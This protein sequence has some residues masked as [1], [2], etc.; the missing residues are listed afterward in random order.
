MYIINKNLN[1][2]FLLKR[3]FTMFFALLIVALGFLL[4]EHDMNAQDST[5]LSSALTITVIP[6]P[7]VELVKTKCDGNPDGDA[8][9][10]ND[11]DV[12][13]YEVIVTFDSD[14]GAGNTLGVNIAAGTTTD[15]FTT[16]A[17]Q[18]VY[19]FSSDPANPFA[20]VTT[21]APIPVTTAGIV[22]ATFTSGGIVYTSDFVLAAEANCSCFR[23]YCTDVTNTADAGIT[24]PDGPLTPPTGTNPLLETIYVLTDPSGAI[25]QTDDVDPTMVEF[26]MSALAPTSAGGALCQVWA[27]NFD[28]T[29]PTTATYVANALDLTAL[30]NPPSP[31]LY[32]DVS[33]SSCYIEKLPAA[34]APTGTPACV[35]E[36]DAAGGQALLADCDTDNGTGSIITWYL[37]DGVTQVATGPSFDPLAGAFVDSNTPGVTTFFAQCTNTDGCSSPL[38]APINFTVKATPEAPEPTDV[39]ICADD[40]DGDTQ[41]LIN[42]DV[43]APGATFNVYDTDGVTLLS[44]AGGVSAPIDVTAFVTTD[45]SGI[46]IQ[47]LYV[48]EF[49]ATT[50]SQGY[51]V[52]ES[53]LA[54]FELKVI[55]NPNPTLDVGPFYFCNND[56]GTDLNT[57]TMPV[58]SGGE[59]FVYNPVTMGPSSSLVSPAIVP[60]NYASGTYGFIYVVTSMGV[61]ASCP[62]CSSQSLPVT[63]IICDPT[64]TAPGSYCSFC[65]SCPQHLHISTVDAAQG[66]TYQSSQTITSDAIVPSGI[67]LNYKSHCIELTNNFKVSQ[68]T[69]FT[70]EIDPCNN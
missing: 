7:T 57:L 37:A 41:I 34:L 6:A 53:D 14:P 65:E 46:G 28:S 25:L 42:F 13:T 43:I 5:A 29:D 54:L 36:G 23:N 35:C 50:T 58:T 39:C 21:L 9:P 51:V 40:A 19:I 15:T 60:A 68:G 64:W 67:D 69:E 4:Y 8:D 47:Q 27:V 61:E 62:D 17:G 24:T 20:D 10:T 22:T 59:W 56:G 45:A 2:R 33:F 55:A 52:C 63:V 3:K 30:C 66:G 70:V 49:V 48:S 18:L 12:Y 26:D 11:V 31:F 1:K 32:I 16:I 38:S 44:P